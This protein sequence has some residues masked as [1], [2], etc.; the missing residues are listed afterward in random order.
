MCVYIYRGDFLLFSDRKEREVL[1]GF[2]SFLVGLLK[3][4]EYP[5]RLIT[6]HVILESRPLS[7]GIF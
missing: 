7:G 6:V 1:K 3:T 5:L 2:P 4:L